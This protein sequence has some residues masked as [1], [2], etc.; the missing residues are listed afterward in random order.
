VPLGMVR[1][2]WNGD[3][4]EREVWVFGCGIATRS[5]AGHDCSERQGIHAEMV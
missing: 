3:I 2:V 1:W 5:E 4:D